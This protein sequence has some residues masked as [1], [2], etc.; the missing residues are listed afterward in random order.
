[1]NH[2]PMPRLGR[3]VPARFTGGAPVPVVA[4]RPPREGE[5]DAYLST[6]QQVVERVD[7]MSCLIGKTHSTRLRNATEGPVPEEYSAQVAELR[8][9]WRAATEN[10]Y[11]CLRIRRIAEVAP[12]R[13]LRQ[14]ARRFDALKL[15]SFAAS[16]R[17]LDA[18]RSRAEAVTVVCRMPCLPE[19][20]GLCIGCAAE[21]TRPEQETEVA[22]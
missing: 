19:E 4:P 20:G 18:A 9:A 12:P 17:E 15:P 16:V 22:A 1:M 7:A 11:R 13:L 2:P 6:A 3:R 10:G 8:F 21:Y 14:I 5:L